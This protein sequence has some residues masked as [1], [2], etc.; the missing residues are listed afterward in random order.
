MLIIYSYVLIKMLATSYTSSSK[1]NLGQAIEHYLSTLD[2]KSKSNFLTALCRYTLPGF[3]KIKPSKD[4]RSNKKDQ[5]QLVEL[6]KSIEIDDFEELLKV[7]ERYFNKIDLPKKK[8]YPYTSRIK[9][10]VDFFPKE[11]TQKTTNSKSSRKR[12]KYSTKTIPTI[13]KRNRYSLDTYPDSLIKEIADYEDFLINRL[14]IPAKASIENNTI[15]VKRIIGWLCL[16]E[17]ISYEDISLDAIV[18]LVRLYNFTDKKNNDCDEKFWMQFAYKKLQGEWKCKD[19]GLKL[20]NL[21][22]EYIEERNYAPSTGFTVVSRFVNLAKYI[23]REETD[24]AIY[25]NYEDIPLIAILRKLGNAYSKQA[26]ILF[27]TKNQNTDGKMVSWQQLQDLLEIKR[28]LFEK[29]TW[30]NGQKARLT[31]VAND[32]QR[33]LILA[34]FTIMPP[35]RQRTFVELTYGKTLKHGLYNDNFTHFTPIEQMSNPQEAQYYIRLG[36]GEYKTWKTYGVWTGRIPNKK[37]PDGKYFYDYLNEWF[38][39]GYT[40]KNG[41]R[42]GYRNS[43]KPRTD[44]VFVNQ[45]GETLTDCTLRDRITNIVY[46]EYK[47]PSTPHTIRHIFVNY[48][49]TKDYDEKT[50]KSFAYWMK[51]SPEEQ[52][53]TYSHLTAADKLSAAQAAMEELL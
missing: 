14:G 36:A 35:D 3:A 29:K 2:S 1:I 8:R 33:F 5:L 31:T 43:L 26:E 46:G 49:H 42:Y 7:Q 18:P 37:F 4:Q 53:K 6:A 40:D 21:I 34:C 51:H 9:S 23:Y 52:T 10:F 22:K 13:R 44:R 25:E 30:R 11:D 50:L 41:K 48:I 32:L 16:H 39:D 27:K 17:K 24:R 15:F 45:K 38:F 12:G 19:A 47:I 20:E 28:Q